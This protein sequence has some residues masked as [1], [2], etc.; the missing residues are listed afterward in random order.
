MR[1][2][3]IA[4]VRAQKPAPYIWFQENSLCCQKIRATKA[5]PFFFFANKFSRTFSSTFF[6]EL[7]YLLCKNIKS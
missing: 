7:K 3:P 6:H 1:S 2:I 4:I 5:P